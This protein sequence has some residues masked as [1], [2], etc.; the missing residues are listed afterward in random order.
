MKNSGFTLIELLVVILIIGI[1]AAAALPQYQKAVA[2]S[3]FTQLQTA[4]KTLKDAMELY[5]MANG[6]YPNYWS[7]LDMEYPG[8]PEGGA[9]YMLWCDKFVVDMFDGANTNLV[10]WDTHG[11]PNHGK[12]MSSLQLREQALSQY[13]I[14]LDNSKYPGKMECRSKITGLCQTLGY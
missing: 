10:L 7:E 11:L 3:R 2:K 6:D 8:C 12:T 14:W 4:G 1:L 9:H 5:Y 13:I